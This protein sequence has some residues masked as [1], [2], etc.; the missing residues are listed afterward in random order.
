MA[1]GNPELISKTPTEK[2]VE[3][4]ILHWLNSV[5]I[6]AW[7]NQSTGV[8]DPRKKVFRISHNK[9]A[10]N[11]VSDILGILPEGRILAIEVKKPCKGIRTKDQL[12]KLA[13]EAQRAF[14]QSV[15][16]RGGLAIVADRLAIVEQQ[17]AY[18]A[19]SYNKFK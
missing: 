14:I 13:S 2:Q 17:L 12:L 19:Y 5:G 9:Y 10:I 4:Q 11:G 18:Y 7:K 15:N 6:F 1:K 8:Y 16:N 3:N